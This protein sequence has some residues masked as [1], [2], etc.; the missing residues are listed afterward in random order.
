MHNVCRFLTV[1]A[2]FQLGCASFG[3]S[4]GGAPAIIDDAVARDAESL[5]DTELL[6]DVKTLHNK[7]L[8]G[9]EV[10]AGLCL[11]QYVKGRAAE[12][13]LAVATDDNARR[14]AQTNMVGGYITCAAQCDLAATDMLSA[15][16]PIAEKYRAP[17]AEGSA[18]SQESAGT[19]RLAELVE[20]YREADQPLGLFFADR[21]ATGAVEYLRSEN[22]DNETVSELA[23]EIE[24][25]R[26]ANA[27]AIDQGRQFFEGAA[28]Q[29]N[30][31]QRAANEAE[32]GSI[33]AKINRLGAELIEADQAGL[34]E[35]AKNIEIEIG[36]ELLRL[37]AT[38]ATHGQLKK[39]Y[40]AMAA[41]AGVYGP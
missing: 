30:F 24:A 38:I 1:A 28:A 33:E 9:A 41:E 37:A 2:L 20:I 8:R 14:M 35:R 7:R 26:A 22:M 23:A 13:E 4:L 40:E 15:Y 10:Y 12:A 32:Q 18:A 19:D 21:D 29:A 39:Q 11:Q 27:D 17:C 5:G 6:S 31:H 25:L 3:A 34:S 16:T 36:A